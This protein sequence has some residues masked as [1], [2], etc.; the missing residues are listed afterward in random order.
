[1][2]LAA[3]RYSGKPFG[4]KPGLRDG[5][6]AGAATRVG[7]MIL[8]SRPK[9]APGVRTEI[10]EHVVCDRALGLDLIDVK[11]AA[12]DASWSGL[13]LVIRKALR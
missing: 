13:K 10:T 1:M 9:W 4:E 8:V 12:V 2:E 5:M 7:G 6:A 11:A 3:A